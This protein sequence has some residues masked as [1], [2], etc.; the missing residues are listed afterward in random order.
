MSD[1][2]YKFPITAWV[3]KLSV[4]SA[5]LGGYQCFCLDALLLLLLE[6]HQMF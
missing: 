3:W 1:V 6:L 5:A 4:R 2:R